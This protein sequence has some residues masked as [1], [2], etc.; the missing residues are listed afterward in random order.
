MD[1]IRFDALTRAFSRRIDR[2]TTLR[3]FLGLGGAMIAGAMATSETEAARR[4]YSGPKGP[5]G[6]SGQL[7]SSLSDTCQG[8]SGCNGGAGLCMPGYDTPNISYCVISMS[9]LY[10]ACGA[11]Q[12]HDDCFYLTGDQHSPCLAHDEYCRDCGNLGGA[13]G[14]VQP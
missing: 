3:A 12:T 2:R 7:C 13:C 14:V 10:G 5:T 8:G 1:E 4:G 11:C 9:P 6:S